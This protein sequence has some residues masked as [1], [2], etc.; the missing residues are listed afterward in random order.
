MNGIPWGGKGGAFSPAVAAS[1][2]SGLLAPEAYGTTEAPNGA[3][4]NNLLSISSG[5]R[6][7]ESHVRYIDANPVK[8]G[9]A[10]RPEEYQ[11]CSAHGKYG[12]DPWP[13][14]SGA[15]APRG[16]G[17]DGG[18]EAPPFPCTTWK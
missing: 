6:G 16:A 8:K 11:F 4:R 13:L 9:L 14:P 2:A 3:W 7:Y 10:E 15:K 18:A 12:L 5:P 1:G 17:R